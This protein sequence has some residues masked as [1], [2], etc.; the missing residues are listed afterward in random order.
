MSC[1]FQ[2]RFFFF[3][4]FKSAAERADAQKVFPPRHFSMF[5]RS[6][7]DSGGLSITSTMVSRL[8]SQKQHLRSPHCRL[9]PVF[10]MGRSSPTF[11]GS[12][13]PPRISPEYGR[14]FSEFP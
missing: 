2:F 4:F 9:L 11:P 10:L 8:F 7:G 13:F 12:S 6:W 14:L 3:F 1:L 5:V